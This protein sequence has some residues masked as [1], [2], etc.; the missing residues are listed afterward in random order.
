M[1][2]DNNNNNDDDDDDD[3]AST[4]TIRIAVVVRA[5]L[6]EA[7]DLRKLRVGVRPRIKRA[8]GCKQLTEW[9]N[10]SSHFGGLEKLG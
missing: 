1:V 5:A 10:P 3:D 2:I 4:A 6:S 7:H 8:G 9:N